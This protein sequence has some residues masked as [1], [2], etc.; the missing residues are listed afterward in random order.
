MTKTQNDSASNKMFF[1]HINPC[2]IGK[3]LDWTLVSFISLF[4]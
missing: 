1:L 4:Y 3:I 2:L